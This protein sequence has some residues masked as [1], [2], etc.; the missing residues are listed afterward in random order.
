MGNAHREILCLASGSMLG[1]V[2]VGEATI[3]G[4]QTI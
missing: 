1:S 4:E 3:Y 2:F